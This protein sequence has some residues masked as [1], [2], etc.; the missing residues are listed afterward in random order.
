[1]K[2][3]PQEKGEVNKPHLRPKLSL[4]APFVYAFSF[5]NFH[6]FHVDHYFLPFINS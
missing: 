6:T 4:P 1:M 5:M 2:P 3:P